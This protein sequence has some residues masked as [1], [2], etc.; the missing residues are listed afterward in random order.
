MLGEW[1]QCTM[2]SFVKAI[3]WVRAQEGWGQGHV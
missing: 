3:V 2:M 1:E